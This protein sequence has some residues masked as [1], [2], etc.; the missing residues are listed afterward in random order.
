LGWAVR[1]RW[2][3]LLVDGVLGYRDRVFP[4]F[5]VSS[6]LILILEGL[7]YSFNYALGY[8]L[9]NLWWN[10][11]PPVLHTREL[12]Y[13]RL[14][15]AERCGLPSLQVLLDDSIDTSIAIFVLAK[16]H[17]PLLHLLG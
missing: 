6:H 2:K 12:L 4:F 15:H 1:W 5:L 8:L 16:D 17:P 10:V 9:H 14:V 7:L 3:V 13:P 11:N